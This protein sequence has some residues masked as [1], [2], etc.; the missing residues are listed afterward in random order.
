MHA[1]PVE[2]VPLIRVSGDVAG[3]VPPY[4]EHLSF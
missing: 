1:R 3:K 4:L 2:F